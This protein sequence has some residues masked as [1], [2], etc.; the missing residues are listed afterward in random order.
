MRKPPISFFKPFCPYVLMDPRLSY[1]TD[2]RGI[3]ILATSVTTRQE[4]RNLVKIGEKCRTQI[5]NVVVAGDVDSS[6]EHCCATLNIFMYCW[7]W[8]VAQRFA[9]KALLGFSCKQWL[10]ERAAVWSCTYITCGV[11]IFS[12]VT[13]LSWLWGESFSFCWS[14]YII[15]K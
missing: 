13:S 9:Q 8:Y 2:F 1:W 6:Q 12:I 15:R 14:N 3:F 10:R 11:S 4:G 7:Q 5:L